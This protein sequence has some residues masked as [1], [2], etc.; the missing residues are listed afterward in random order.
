MQDKTL[1]Q[2]MRQELIALGIE[3]MLTPGETDAELKS[4][5]G[6]T[7]IFINSTCGCAAATARPGIK[8]ALSHEILPEKLRSVFAGQDI[9]A[10][11]RVR[12]YIRDYPSSSPS[13]ALFK[14]GEVVYM[15]ERGDILSSTPSKLAADLTSA[16]DR[17]CV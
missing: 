7:L 6:T 3:E 2:Q 8:L 1:I 11:Q 15:I 4:H 17:Y 9:E 10:T 5:K 14:N 16:F 13:I 12:E